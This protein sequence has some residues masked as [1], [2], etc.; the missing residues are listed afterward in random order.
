MNLTAENFSSTVDD[1]DVVLIDFWADWCGPCKTFG[2]IYDEVAEAHPD[3]VFGKVDTDAEQALAGEFG[4]RSIPTLAV[5]RDNVL[6][7]SQAGVLPAD[8]LEDVIRQVRELD[9]EQAH[10]DIAAQAES[11]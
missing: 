8:A 4:I 11:A 6:L 10:R 1:N 2:P 5:I 3:L 7:F 9:M